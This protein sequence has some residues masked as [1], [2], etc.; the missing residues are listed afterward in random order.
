MPGKIPAHI[1]K[2]DINFSEFR[3]VN[4]EKSVKTVKTDA[5]H[6]NV[7]QRYKVMCEGPN[8]TAKNVRFSP[9]G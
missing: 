1:C 5:R 6:T 3:K 4:K 7:Y 8:E 2:S 9:P